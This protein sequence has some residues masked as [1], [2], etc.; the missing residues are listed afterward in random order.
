MNAIQSSPSLSVAIVGGGRAGCQLLDL[1]KDFPNCH[2]VFLADLDPQAPAVLQ[3]QKAGIPTFSSYQDA[4]KQHR[5]DIL[6]E[7]TNS[8]AVSE[9]LIRQSA[10]HQFALVTHSAAFL[11]LSAIEGKTQAIQSDVVSEISDIQA[12]ILHSLKQINELVQGIQTITAEMRIIAINAR[13]EAARAGDHGRGFGVVAQTMGNS[14]DATRDLSDQIEQ[15]N[16]DIQK[17]VEQIEAA[18]TKLR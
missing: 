6:F 1:F 4:L 5:T 13:I 7:V 14:V 3:A 16:Q 2:I 18:L 9:D 12:K 15:L 10:Q 11:T 17:V 8:D